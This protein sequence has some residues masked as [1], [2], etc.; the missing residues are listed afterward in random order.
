MFLCFRKAED[1]TGAHLIQVRQFHKEELIQQALHHHIPSKMCASIRPVDTAV[2]ESSILSRTKNA[3]CDEFFIF[4]A[5]KKIV[6]SR[7]H[8]WFTLTLYL[9][10]GMAFVI[11]SSGTASL[12]F[13]YPTSTQISL[14]R[15]A[16]Q[17]PSITVCSEMPFSLHK[18]VQLGFNNSDMSCRPGR[19]RENNTVIVMVCQ[20]DEMM[21]PLVRQLEGLPSNLTVQRVWNDTKLPQQLLISQD[22]SISSQEWQSVI[23]SHNTCYKYSN[24]VL[25]DS[26]GIVQFNVTDQYQNFNCSYFFPDTD[27]VWVHYL[28]LL[29][30]VNI[31]VVAHG[32]SPLLL[33]HDI[34]NHWQVSPT[35]ICKQYFS[36]LREVVISYTVRRLIDTPA[37]PCSSSSL[38]SQRNCVEECIITKL[39]HH[40]G[41][42]PPYLPVDDLQQC[43]I[44]NLR[45]GSLVFESWDMAE[46]RGECKQSCPRQCERV[47]LKTRA[48]YAEIGVQVCLS[49]LVLG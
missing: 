27:C 40:H 36:C 33:S 16:V 46:V 45:N 42:A 35:R 28:G 3:H 15:E 30:L 41:C 2:G 43:T 34:T 11:H 20:V 49:W 31:H 38:Y 18:M 8:M 12:Y 6:C 37:A 4:A 17:D 44:G 1:E 7:L 48:F 39:S 19:L 29:K 24:E 23:T 13:S 10:F 14:T 21:W 25:H 9:A 22:S 5:F 26:Q 32:E 47:F